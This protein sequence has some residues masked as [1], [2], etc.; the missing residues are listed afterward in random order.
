MNNPS[1]IAAVQMVSGGNLEEN[2][3]TAANL[4]REAAAKG[5]SLLCLPENFAL[6]DSSAVV[7][8]GIEEARS[9]RIRSFIGHLSRELGVWIVAGSIPLAESPDNQGVTRVSSACLVFNDRG[10][11]LARY[12]KIHLFDVNVGDATGI[13]RES[14]RFIP[15]NCPVVVDSPMGVLGLSICYDLRFPE[16]FVDLRNKGAEIILV[17]SAFTYATGK[18]HWSTLLRARAIENQCYVVG[19][20]QGGQH[21]A[22]RRTWGHTMIVDPWGAVL[23]SLDEGEGVVI[24][25][26]DR[27]RLLNIREKMP[28]TEHRRFHVRMD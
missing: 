2:L 25:T 4:C 9:A 7:A 8:L 21:N 10:E 3:A 20:N 17:P 13:Y 26:V 22:T 18:D 23:S 16:L 28:I 5:A 11:C 12:D 15:G 14:D 19:I 24:A 27:E 6:L 1:V